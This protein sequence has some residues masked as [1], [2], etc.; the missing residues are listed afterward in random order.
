MTRSPLRHWLAAMALGGCLA[1]PVQANDTVSLVFAGDVV[2]D[3]SVNDLIA[4]GRSICQLPR[5]LP[6]PTSAANL[7]CVVATIS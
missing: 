1:A 2:L 4:R 7:E 5:Y 6:M 3:D